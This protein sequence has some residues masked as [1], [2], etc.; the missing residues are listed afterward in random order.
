M[1]TWEIK[2][3]KWKN[4]DI[5]IQVKLENDTVWLTQEQISIIFWVK[6]P[7][8]TKHIS[9]IFK[10]WELEEEAVCSILEHTASDGKNY[11]TNFYNLD[12]IISIGYRVNS[13]EATQ[14]RIW[15]TSVLKKY[16]ISWY[17]L[18]QKRLQEKWYIE[19]ENTLALL[20]KTISSWNI[21][22]DEALGLLDIITKYTN[23]WVLLQKYD[24]DS[25]I[26]DDENIPFQIEK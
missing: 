6:R 15:A 25:L 8:I 20:K 5:E 14:F 9:N 23:T 19:L 12:M 26:F 13:K 3:Y 7:A 21:W 24:E 4:A 10:S 1:N 11:K 22:K 16:L 17:T 2:I 18:N